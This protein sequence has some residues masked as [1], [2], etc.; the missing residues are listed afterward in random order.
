MACLLRPFVTEAGRYVKVTIGNMF[1]FT[2]R[3]EGMLSFGRARALTEDRLLTEAGFRAG[4]HTAG[5]T[6]TI[7]HTNRF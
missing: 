3:S 1:L 4:D 5:Y 6:T 2:T 7:A